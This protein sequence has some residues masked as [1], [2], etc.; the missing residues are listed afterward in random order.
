MREARDMRQPE[1]AERM[2]ISPRTLQ[3]IENGERPNPGIR[4]LVNA[5][6]VLNCA[7]EDICEDEWLSWTPF[8][9]DIEPPPRQSVKIR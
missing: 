9:K 6:L 1:L 3:A 2:G 7:L 5:A 8:R 4:V